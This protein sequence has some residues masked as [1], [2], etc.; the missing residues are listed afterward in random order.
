MSVAE[1]R[2]TLARIEAVLER[3]ATAAE[4]IAT[5]PRKDDFAEF[6]QN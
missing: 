3:L 4:A 5:Q 2:L 1:M 6:T